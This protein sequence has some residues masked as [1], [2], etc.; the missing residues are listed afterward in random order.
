MAGDLVYLDD[1]GFTH[2]TQ[3]LAASPELPKLDPPRYPALFAAFGQALKTLHTDARYVLDSFPVAVCHNTRIPR[4]KLRQDQ[5]YHGRCASKRRWFYSFKVQLLTTPDGVPVEY[6]I[7]AG[8][9]A[10]QTGRRGLAQDLPEGSVRY[11][12]AGYPDYGAEDM[13]EQATGNRQQSAR[14]KNSQRPREPHVSFLMQHFRKPIA[15]SF[16]QL[17]ARSPKQI[18]ATTAQGFVL[19]LVLFLFARSLDHAGLIVRNLG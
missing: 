15:T 4:C 11:T 6:S 19:K 10:D 16:R 9:G 8:A 2:L 17:T 3:R 1:E 13:F 18:P 12:D 5:A 14:K 7:H